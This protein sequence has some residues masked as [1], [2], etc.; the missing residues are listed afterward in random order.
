MRH[1]SPDIV[2][3]PSLRATLARILGAL[4]IAAA[5]VAAATLIYGIVNFP[6]APIRPTARGYTG[7]TGTTRTEEDY[8]AFQQWETALLVVFPTAFGLG[9]AYAI[10]SGRRRSGRP[11]P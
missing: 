8:R 10:A 4:T 11:R 9:L 2:G 5:L 1:G 3:R 7:K 6:D